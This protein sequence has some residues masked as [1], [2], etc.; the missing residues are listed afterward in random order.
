ME[1]T[2]HAQRRERKLGV[3]QKEFYF[4]RCS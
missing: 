4:K 3:F 2:E 1:G